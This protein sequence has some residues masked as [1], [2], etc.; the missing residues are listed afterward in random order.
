M[1]ANPGEFKEIALVRGIHTE[2]MDRS[3]RRKTIDR[4]LPDARK[5]ARSQRSKISQRVLARMDQGMDRRNGAPRGRRRTARGRSSSGKPGA[6]PAERGRDL[7]NG[8]RDQLAGP[9]PGE[10][11]ADPRCNG[12]AC[13]AVAL[14][15]AG[16]EPAFTGS[17]TEFRR[18][19]RDSDIA[20]SSLSWIAR[21]GDDE[22]DG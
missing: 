21:G 4:E 12:A 13:G 14:T 17:C 7:T 6:D 15:R 19:L 22:P 3:A 16:S 5:A 11:P 8:S 10:K 18:G 20:I 1:A 9:V 2:T